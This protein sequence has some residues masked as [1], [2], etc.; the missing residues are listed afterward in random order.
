MTVQA[1]KRIVDRVFAEAFNRGE[2]AVIDEA[3]ADHAIDHQHPD[4]PSLREHLKDAV[5]ALRTAFPDLRF[6]LTEIIGEGEWV[7]AHSFMTGT[8]TG[9]LRRPVLPPNAPP[10]IPATGRAVRIAHMHLIRFEDGRN[11]ELWHVMDSL[12][13]LGQL[14]LLPAPESAG[15]P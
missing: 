4:E 5:V 8:N 13:L 10:T 6:T 2:L 7:A 1:N 15:R 11:T 14:G 12:A 9:E 3:V